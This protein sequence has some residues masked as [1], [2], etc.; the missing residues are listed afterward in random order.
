M[1]RLVLRFTNILQ[2]ALGDHG[3]EAGRLRGDLAERFRAA[4]QDVEDRRAAGEI[5]FF[6]LPYATE[7]AAQTRELADG[8]GQWFENVVLLGIGGS[9]L[10]TRTI[11][12]A[13]LGPLWNEWSDEDRDHY[14][15]LYVLDNVDPASARALLGRIDLRRTLFVVVSKSGSTAETMACYLVAEGLVRDEVGEDKARGHFL[16]VTDP[17]DGALR[18]IAENEG[19]PSL[20]IPA[21]VGGRFSVLSPAGLL[22]A[23]I[24]GVDI[25]ALLEGAAK[26][27][28]RCR[29]ESLLENPAGLI[30]T[31]LHTAD[32]ELGRPIHVL[33]PYSDRL[34]SFA[35]WF[36][37]LWAESLGKARSLSGEVVNAGP[38]PL[39]AVG[40][41]DQHAQLQL[42][43]EGPHDKV[44]LILGVGD[45]GDP[46]P[47][48]E[49]RS[50]AAGLGYLGG[51]TLLAL[52]ESE[53]LATTEALRQAGRPSM[54]LEMARLDAPTLGAL[55]QLFETAT[56]LAGALY[57]V[58]PLDQPGVELG[59]RLT[60]GLMGRP[61]F[62]VPSL[63]EGDLEDR[64]SIDLA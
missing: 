31:L 24:T 10:G 12:D 40:V 46:V 47:I 37:Q 63:S 5:G 48:P 3:I 13:L 50:G 21:N 44:V 23:A 38:T 45:E 56:V 28:E 51:S 20:P 15:R 59:K 19:V 22:P 2:S 60:Y 27:E 26:M 36:Q 17:T 52:F 18:A 35:L 57:G 9:A 25:D 34:R 54:S 4:L 30:A 62:E 11:R 7:S 33:M 39:P 43:M 41:T 55:F 32:T 6:D 14:P 53:R 16:L 61:G 42:F 58:D 8:F 1:S 49:H 64:L 29:A